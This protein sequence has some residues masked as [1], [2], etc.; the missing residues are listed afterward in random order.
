MPRKLARLIGVVAI[1]ASAPLLSHSAVAQPAPAAPAAAPAQPTGTPVRVR[2]TITGLE[3]NNL[4]FTTREGLAI[5]IALAENFTVNAAVPL[6]L[7][8]ITNNAYIGVAA[9]QDAAGNYL[10]LDL[11]LF[12]EAQRGAGEGQRAWDL[13]PG[14]VMINA[15]VTVIEQQANGTLIRLTFPD[16][17]RDVLIGPET[18]IWTTTPGDRSLLV[19]GADAVI[20]TRLQENGTYTAGAVTVEKDGT[21]PTN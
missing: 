6:T 4:G 16:G 5:T 13:T 19:P 17:T 9:E 8:D 10:A 15:T 1:V 18:S 3:G 21:R 14:A 11:R 2:G 20:G 7:A 12:A